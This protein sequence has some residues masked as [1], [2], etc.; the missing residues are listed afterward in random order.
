M[1]TALHLRCGTRRF[2]LGGRDHRISAGTRLDEPPEGYVDAWMWAAEFD[3][4]LTMVG[5]RS[6]LDVRRPAPGDPIRCL[7]FPNRLLV[8]QMGM[9]AIRAKQR[10]LRSSQPSLAI[11]VGAD[12][13]SVIDPNTNALI[14]S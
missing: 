12:A 9:W 1:G 10:L 5:R 13:I 11:D 8:H 3:E 6:G 14:A 2:V 7:L 4:L